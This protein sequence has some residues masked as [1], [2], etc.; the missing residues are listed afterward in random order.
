MTSVLEHAAHA[1]RG[2]FQGELIGPDATEY[3]RAR[4]V[5]NGAIDHR[6]AV[7][8]RCTGSE[9]VA[10]ALNFARA[11]GLKISVRGGSHSFAGNAVCPDGLV[12]DL[13]PLNKVE[14]DPAERLARCGGGATLAELD[15]ATQAHALAV[16]SGTISHT[17]VGGLALGGGFGWLTPQYGLTADN[18]LAAEVV[19]ADGTVVRAAE[20]ENADLFWALRGGGGN[21]GVVTTFL[22]RLHEVGPEVQ[23]GLFFWDMAQSDEA[24]G[25][26]GE[27]VPALPRKT[28]V[29]A[30]IGLSAPPEDFVPPEHVGTLGQA[31]IV[32]GFGT[33][34]EHAEAVAPLAKGPPTLFQMRTP[35]PYTGLQ[36]M[37]DDAAPFG[38]LAYEKSLPFTGF[39]EDTIALFGDQL[40]RKSSPMTFCPT[41]YLSG[42][43]TD[44]AEDATAFGGVREPT[45]MVSMAAVTPDRDELTADTAWVRSLWTEMLPH[46][47]NPG[48][49]VNFMVESE[50]DRIRA[51]YG[52]A[53]YERLAAIKAKYDP[54]NVFNRNANILP[55]TA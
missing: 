35:M 6:P 39:D 7:V 45:Y 37:L 22:F 3:D 38:I 52:A 51:A 33:A 34:E 16:P 26:I 4:S 25:L 48:G 23:V 42:A 29:L 24:L 30:G 28:G 50:E 19:L 17:G 1:L 27:T 43:F 11:E 47:A 2:D 14:V 40:P 49:Y 13:S 10:A 53:K 44:V 12:V 54:H 36:S 20:G 55:G 21:F 41:F 46:A 8:A 32:A 18:L 31:L 15:A 5:W 9:D